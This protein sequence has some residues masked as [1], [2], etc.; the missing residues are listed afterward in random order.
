MCRLYEGAVCMLGVRCEG[1]VYVL[2]GQS[3]RFY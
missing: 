1:E 2:N 3:L